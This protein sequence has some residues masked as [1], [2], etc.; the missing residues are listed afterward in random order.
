MPWKRNV[1]VVANVTAA[2]DELLAALKARAEK[3]PAAFTLIVPATPFGGG[4]RAA[5][6][7]V[8]EAVAQ[9]RQAGL[10]AAGE[11][12]DG[13]PVIAVTE[14]W[15]PKQFDEIVVSTLPMR[16]RPSP[17]PSPPACSRTTAPRMRWVRSPCSDGE[18][19]R[20]KAGN[21]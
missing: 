17:S 1:L 19:T 9:L 8:K 16:S 2:S 7:K 5:E 20:K 21:R 10:E 14:K 3:D 13:D 12:G 4:R 15:D 6:A 11:V 18:V